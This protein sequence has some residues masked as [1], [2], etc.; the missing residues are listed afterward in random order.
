MNSNVAI[1]L[2]ILWAAATIA[3]FAW[4]VSA[5][6]QLDN[7][8]STKCTGT[9][10]GPCPA[11]AGPTLV[12]TTYNLLNP[13]NEAAGSSAWA[14]WDVRKAGIV[15]ALQNEASADVFGFQEATQTQRT[16]LTSELGSEY[17]WFGDYRKDGQECNPLVYRK[18]VLERI[19]GATVRFPDQPTQTD[20]PIYQRIYT[21]GLFRFVKHP[22]YRVL[23]VCTHMYKKDQT[24]AQDAARGI[25]QDFINQKRQELGSRV[26][27]V[28]MA[29]WNPTET[30]SVASDLV[31][32]SAGTLEQTTATQSTSIG[33]RPPHDKDKLN[34]YMIYARDGTTFLAGGKFDCFVYSKAQCSI[35]HRT[36]V[37]HLRSSNAVPG[38][39]TQAFLANSDHDPALTVWQF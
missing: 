6:V 13:A 8:K 21:W 30:H 4:A 16:Y 17:E 32:N 14:G 12:T 7:Q 1:A 34:E 2:F 37:R 24:D 27:F 22:L 31:S 15:S 9:D 18:A 38:G 39:S 25:L 3:F 19:D 10:C 35:V 28:L 5:Q 23:L 26:P 11:G 29:D 36:V 20:D 33:T